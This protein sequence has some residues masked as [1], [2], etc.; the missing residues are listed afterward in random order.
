[1]GSVLNPETGVLQNIEV[2]SSSPNTFRDII[3]GGGV[4]LAGIT[5][6]TVSAFKNG[7]MKMEEAELKA[8]AEAG[9]LKKHED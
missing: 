8:L 6:L 2:K 7:A 5:Y 9:L 3:I 1:M 4:I